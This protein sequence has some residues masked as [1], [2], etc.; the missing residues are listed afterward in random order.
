MRKCQGAKISYIPSSGIFLVSIANWLLACVS[1]VKTR[2]IKARR[3]RPA[4][5]RR[6]CSAHRRNMPPQF[7]VS[8]YFLSATAPAA[9]IRF[10]F[11][12]ISNLAK[13]IHFDRGGKAWCEGDS[14]LR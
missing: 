5:Y 7:Y 8:G 1:L 13:S 10:F 3:E 9:K 14:E 6:P 4:A 12:G 2:N 11:A